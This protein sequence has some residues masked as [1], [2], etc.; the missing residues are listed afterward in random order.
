MFKKALPTITS[1]G[2]PRVMNVFGSLMSQTTCLELSQ[3][4][5]TQCWYLLPVFLV[6]FNS[7]FRAVLINNS[8]RSP[9]DGTELMTPIWLLCGEYIIY[10]LL[11]LQPIPELGSDLSFQL[12]DTHT[13]S[14]HAHA[15]VHTGC[16]R[17]CLGLDPGLMSNA[18]LFGNLCVAID[19]ISFK[20]WQW[21]EVQR[22]V[23]LIFNWPKYRIH[24]IWGAAESSLCI[25]VYV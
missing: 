5:Q 13:H 4:I 3:L 20:H 7:Q 6:V 16:V 1:R 18:R 11:L 15:Q 22:I 10:Y 2:R 17:S 9:L 24:T 25:S 8:L 19:N 21:Q 12:N 14:S 23:F